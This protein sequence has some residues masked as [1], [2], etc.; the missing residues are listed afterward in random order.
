MV[1]VEQAT[2]EE[3]NVEQLAAD[4]EA[5]GGVVVRWVAVGQ[6]TVVFAKDSTGIKPSVREAERQVG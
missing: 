3:P 4:W 5:I 6:I 2:I 1:A